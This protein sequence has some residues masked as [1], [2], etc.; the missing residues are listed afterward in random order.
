MLN[1]LDYRIG[2]DLDLIIGEVGRFL[3]KVAVLHERLRRL[4]NRRSIEKSEI[5]MLEVLRDL[6]REHLV[7][8]VLELA[9]E[10]DLM[11]LKVSESKYLLLQLETALRSALVV[12]HHLVL[13]PLLYF[14]APLPIL[15]LLLDPV[16]QQ[17]LADDLLRGR[18][19]IVLLRRWS[20]FRV[21]LEQGFLAGF[22]QVGFWQVPL[23]DLRVL[24]L[25]LKTV[26]KFM[27]RHAA[28]RKLVCI[29]DLAEQLVLL[30]V[31]NSV[32]LR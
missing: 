24:F 11:A 6:M 1:A 30:D 8:C 29:V 19:H 22:D 7:E 17:N 4:N 13:A 16:L 20:V 3:H 15:P 12:A 28:L 31:A 21:M 9:A 26:Q 18:V 5:G 2:R 14:L 23:A 25:E 32:L 27:G 10:S